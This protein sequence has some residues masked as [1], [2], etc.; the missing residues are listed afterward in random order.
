MRVCIVTPYDLSHDGG[1]NRHALGLARALG[2]LGVEARVLG[3]A[4]GAVPDGCDGLRGVLPVPANGSVARIGL[5]VSERATRAYLDAHDFDVVHVHEPIV[6]GPGRHALRHAR[7]PVVATFHANAEREP[8]LQSVLRRFASAGL[9]RVDFGIAV[10]RQAKRFA[11]PIF[12]GRIA[13]IPNGVDRSRFGA[14]TDAAPRPPH[15][16]PR[17]LFVGRFGEPRKGLAVLLDAAERLR[18][19]GEA[20]DIEVVGDGPADR[21]AGRAARAGVRFLGRVSDD[22]LARAYRD[23]DVFCAPSLGGESFG[24]VLAEAMA[25]G[26]PVVASDI[27]GYAEAARG[28]ALLVRAGDP[29]ALATALWRAAHDPGLR[30]R[31]WARGRARADALCWSR[32]AARV[33]HI[34]QVAGAG[35]PALAVPP[36]APVARAA[37]G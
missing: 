8:W 5:L 32:V 22:A 7:G 31:L 1:V 17:V 19:R 28:A 35:S 29:D 30:A 23:G 11:R 18:A 3:P 12:R 20:V 4:S 26:C 14:D 6:P 21:W 27:P 33:L 16:P 2:G 15:A 37:R 9:S 10:S 25:A 34:Y 24:M 13:V 36:L